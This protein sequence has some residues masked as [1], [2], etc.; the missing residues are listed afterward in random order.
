MARR[1]IEELVDLDALSEGGRVASPRRIREALPPGWVLD[2]DGQ[3]ARRDLRILAREGWVLALGLVLFG[4][5]AILLFMETLP[6]GWRGFGR[7]ATMIGLVLL[8]GG[9]V[10]PLV[11]RALNRRAGR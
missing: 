10:G 5:A 1:P 9:I 4:G 7:A 2:E 3:S 11:T 8:A 6:K